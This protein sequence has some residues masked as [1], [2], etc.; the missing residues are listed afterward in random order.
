VYLIGPNV[1]SKMI[2]KMTLFQSYKLAEPAFFTMDPPSDLISGSINEK[3]RRRSGNNVNDDSISGSIQAN[4]TK[5]AS[6]NYYGVMLF[7]YKRINISYLFRFGMLVVAKCVKFSVCTAISTFFDLT[8]MSN[9]KRFA[10]N[11]F[12]QWFHKN[13]P[14]C[15][16]IFFTL[17][18]L[19]INYII[20]NI[21]S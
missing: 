14:S 20:S 9:R 13:H 21:R 19:W 17:H 7:V 4:L 5:M 1:F 10:T 18:T 12:Y 11:S 15:K 6:L 3:V 8:S 2:C 16:L